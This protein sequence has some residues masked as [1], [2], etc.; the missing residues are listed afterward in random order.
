M[1]AVKI[2][3][4]TPLMWIWYFI[5]VAL[6]LLSGVRKDRRMRTGWYVLMVGF[7]LFTL[8]SFTPVSDVLTQP[9]ARRYPMASVEMLKN[10]EVIVVL[11]GGGQAGVPSGATYE[12]IVAAVGMFRQGGAKFFVVQG[13]AHIPGDPTDAEIMKNIALEKGVPAEKIL[14]DY[15]SRTTAEH[16]PQLKALLPENVERIGI[17]TSALHMPRAIVVFQKSFPNKSIIPLPVSFRRPRYTSASMVPSVDALA[18]ST[19]ALHEWIGI[20]W[21]AV[22]YNGI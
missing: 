19:A 6:I 16:P 13:A 17:V 2:L 20:I 18:R 9:L 5:L 12:R 7:L 8:L 14:V 22:R 21:Y 3:F 11:G 15:N 1:Q 4:T 10:T